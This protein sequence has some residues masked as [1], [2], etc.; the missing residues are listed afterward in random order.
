MLI[1]LLAYLSVSASVLLIR[2][3]EMHPVQGPR[4]TVPMAEPAEDPHRGFERLGLP[5]LGNQPRLG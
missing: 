4:L 1:Y 5:R 3:Q 2:Q